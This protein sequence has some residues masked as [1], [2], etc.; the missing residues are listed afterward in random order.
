VQFG[1]DRSNLIFD[2]LGAVGV[3][4]GLGVITSLLP[5]IAR[6]AGIDALGLGLLA[7]APFVANVLGLFA[8]RVGP[9]SP[10]QVAILRSLGSAAL[11]ASPL[12]PLHLAIGAVLLWWIGYAFGC[13]LQ[14]R[15]WGVIYAARDRGRLVGLVRTAQT[16]A[17][18]AIGVAGGVLA[19]HFGGPLVLALAGGVGAACVLSYGLVRA[20][21][22]A[23]PP[24]FSPRECLHAAWS[25]PRLRNLLLA[26]LVFG[27]GLAAAT[28][29]FALVQVDA[30]H[31]SLGEIGLLGVLT[32]L[33]TMLSYVVW[34]LLADHKQGGVRVLVAGA[35]FGL[36]GPIGYV[37]AQGVLVLALASIA[38]G[39]SNAAI[40]MGITAELSEGVPLGK[41][42]PLMAAWNGLTGVRG[43][44]F[45]LGVGALVQGG[46]LSPTLALVV[47][48]ALTAAGLVV[49][50]Q[51]AR[52]AEPA[53]DPERALAAHYAPARA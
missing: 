46:W 7:A 9:R 29:L 12:V 45:P 15:L 39:L 1:Y 17:A 40:D 22:A 23:E 27:A 52:K 38:A 4:L 16:A 11:V 5:G 42:A 13:P 32:S 33:A 35:A 44:I 18:A 24:P 10:A 14:L 8:G 25:A 26:Q 37:W 20:P 31:L 50:A 30:L 43:A 28:P 21:A 49:Y 6:E 51:V 41:R 53:E 3:G 36:L 48:C 34:G 19:D 2:A 47:C